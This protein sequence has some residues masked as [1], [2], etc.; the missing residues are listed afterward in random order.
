MRESA[1]KTGARS[2]PGRIPGGDQH[3]VIVPRGELPECVDN[4]VLGLAKFNLAARE[5][6]ETIRIEHTT[7]RAWEENGLID[8]LVDH[9]HRLTGNRAQQV[10][11]PVRCAQQ[12]VVLFDCASVLQS[13]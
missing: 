9:L 3:S 10:G 2:R 7:A 6:I 5:N 8:A 1:A 4:E 11:G 12:A 13:R